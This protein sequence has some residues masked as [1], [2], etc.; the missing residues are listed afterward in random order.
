MQIEL[1]ASRMDKAARSKQ[2]PS[3]DPAQMASNMVAQTMQQ[4][5]LKIPRLQG[6]SF[7]AIHQFAVEFRQYQADEGIKRAGQC[8]S[9]DIIDTLVSLH[10]CEPITFR[11]MN[12]DQ[13][14][15][16]LCVNLFTTNLLD[17]TALLE[18]QKQ[19]KPRDGQELKCLEKY[20]QLFKLAIYCTSRSIPTVHA[21]AQSKTFTNGIQDSSLRRCLKAAGSLPVDELY[22]LARSTTIAQSRIMRS[23]VKMGFTRIQHQ[24]NRDPRST[25]S[26]DLPSKAE[27]SKDTST[28][29]G[30]GTAAMTVKPQVQEK[31]PRS[32]PAARTEGQRANLVCFNC[33]GDHHARDCPEPKNRDRIQSGY[34]AIN[35][36]ANTAAISHPLTSNVSRRKPVALATTSAQSLPDF[37]D[38]EYDDED[39]DEVQRNTKDIIIDSG[40]T[41]Y[42]I[43]SPHVFTPQP[44]PPSRRKKVR[45]ATG[46]ATP[47]VASGSYLDTYEDAKM[48]PAF[49]QSLFSVSKFNE[50]KKAVTIFNG[51]DVIGVKRN[52]HIDKLL[53]EIR[54]TASRDNLLHFIAPLC[55]GLYQTTHNH[56]RQ[57]EKQHRCS[58]AIYQT[59]RLATLPD[60]VL[61]FHQAWG[62]ANV[63]QMHN[64]VAHKLPLLLPPLRLDASPRLSLRHRPSRVQ[65]WITRTVITRRITTRY[66]AT[67]KTSSL[68]L[69][70]QII[71]S[72]HLMS[73]LPNLF[74]LPAGRR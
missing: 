8:L 33:D 63:K 16:Y 55:D 66:N 29:T 74:P 69:G 57:H 3:T 68:I 43:N 49:T 40:A 47:I 7:M 9:G 18:R 60:L 65:L 44:V 1:A 64:I 51:E 26:E 39:Y 58:A 20:I 15:H 6:L 71:S 19:D 28:K 30:Q 23:A 34:D 2:A 14:K 48:T 4:F 41:D 22:I 25:R 38:V 52:E 13:L 59:A 54:Q 12:F 21:T 35:Q 72:T 11:G 45:T 10:D 5:N 73:S 46:K 31:K 56:M 17:S 62:C 67:H 53:A 42:F 37:E 61:F 70:Q 24:R 32:I 27:R 50:S 36:R